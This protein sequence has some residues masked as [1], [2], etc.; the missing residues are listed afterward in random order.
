MYRYLMAAALL[1]VHAPIVSAEPDPEAASVDQGAHLI[2][3]SNIEPRDKAR[4]ANVG[5]RPHPRFALSDDFSASSDVIEFNRRGLIDKAIVN[6]MEAYRHACRAGWVKEGGLAPVGQYVHLYNAPNA[7]V[8]SLY[9]AEPSANGA[10]GELRLEYAFVHDG[11][12]SVPSAT[13]IREAI[14]CHAVGVSQAEQERS[15]RCL[16]D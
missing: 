5:C 8:A 12:H 1:G 13:E 14:F 9:R 6:F 10:P 15:G 3:V 16:V 4:F 11:V 2:P 7:N